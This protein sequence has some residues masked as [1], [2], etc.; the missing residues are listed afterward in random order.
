MEIEWVENIGDT[1]MKPNLEALKIKKTF[2]SLINEHIL[3]LYNKETTGH[4]QTK[5]Y[6]LN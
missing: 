5:I 3:F 1:G 4:R 2:I 6:T